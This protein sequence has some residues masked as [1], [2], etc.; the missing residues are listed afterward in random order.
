MHT[1][2]TAPLRPASRIPKLFVIRDGQITA[3]QLSA[4]Q[5]FGRPS[6]T[7][8]PDISVPAKVV[9]RNHGS[10]L[11]VGGSTYYTDTASTNGTL[12]NSVPMETAVRQLLRDGDVLRIHGKDDPAGKLDVVMIYSTSYPACGCDDTLGV[13]NQ[14]S[15]EHC[16]DQITVGRKGAVAL[17]D[18]TV[19]REHAAFYRAEAGWAVLDPGSR[20]GVFINNRRIPH[21]VYLRPMDVIRI[22]IYHFLFTGSMLIYQSD[23]QS[24]A[25]ST[26]PMQNVL[27]GRFGCELGASEEETPGTNL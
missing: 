2:Q 8:Q 23:A 17:Q 13:W 26:I 10:F 11:T 16:T 19:S 6:S 25:A 14:L 1:G 12:Y 3:Y 4:A 27:F 15:L 5:S 18:S 20:N 7:T 22:G 21:P 9:S 24:D